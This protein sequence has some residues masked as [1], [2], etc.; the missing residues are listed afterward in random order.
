M[1]GVRIVSERPDCRPA[2]DVN[3]LDRQTDEARL[4]RAW[5]WRVA[6][7]WGGLGFVAGATFWH[8]VGFWSFLSEVVLDHGPKAQAAAMSAP[9]PQAYSSLPTIVLIDTDRC[10]ALLLDRRA[11]VT[12]ARPCPKSGLALRLETDGGARDDL[13]AL[14]SP[15]VQ[16]AGYRPN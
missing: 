5:R 10:T 12:V 8:L 6:L 1:R 9:P 14:S 3:S 2:P 4:S 13:A 11:K 16:A 7:A 15:R